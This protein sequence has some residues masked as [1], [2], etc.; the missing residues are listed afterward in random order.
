MS[1]NN[2]GNRL[3]ELGRREEALTATQEAVGI[4]RQLAQ[5]NPQAFLPDLATSL[6]NLGYMLSALGR[7]EEALTATQEAVEIRRKLAQ[8]NPQAFLPDLARSMG[9]LGTVLRGLG[10]HEQAADAFGEGLR[11]IV[12]FLRALP[13]AFGGLAGALLEGYLRA[14]PDAGR[15]PDEE[16]VR[17][18]REVLAKGQE[19]G[20]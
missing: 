3:S 2:L 4:Y 10:H 16:L 20:R 6:N 7:R 13:Q 5:A 1:L 9:M 18:V 12:P 17:A 11:A 15:K 14:C 19:E 8:A